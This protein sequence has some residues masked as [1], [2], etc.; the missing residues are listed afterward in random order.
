MAFDLATAK[1][2]TPTQSGGFDLSTAKPVQ[3]P[4]QPQQQSEGFPG[5]SFIEPAATIASAIPAEILGG[6][7]TLLPIVMG[8]PDKA[9][10]N[11]KAMRELITFQP[12]T[13]AGKE[14][15]ESFG[16]A[17]N[18]K[19]PVIDKSVP[20]LLQNTEDAFSKS[21][22]QTFD[23][24]GLDPA[25]GAG[26]GAVIP[27][28]IASAL[29]FK[30]A[31]TAAKTPSIKK[32]T[33]AINEL[34]L[35]AEDAV[36]NLPQTVSN[37]AK[38]TGDV[39]TKQSKFKQGI[40][41]QIEAGGTDN[42][43]A[44]FIVNGAGKVKKD[45]LAIESIKQGF[46]KGVIAAVKGASKTDKAILSKMVTTMERGKLNAKF[47]MKN[48]PSDLAGD[49]LLKRVN[50]VKKVN[51]RA[52]KNI[53]KE[54]VKL[55]GKPVDISKPVNQFA[56]DLNDLGVTLSDNGTGG[57]KP[58]FENSVLAPGDR[59]P[60]REVIRQMNIKGKNGAPDGFTTHKMKR[61]ID[62]N[63]TF[64]KSKTGMSGDAE[65]VLKDFRR[66]L[67]KSL[68]DTF[69]DYNKANTVYAETINSL[70]SLKDVAGR[71][72]DLFGPNADK[73]TGTLL[74]RMMSNAQ[75][76]VNLI[77][78]VDSLESTAKKYGAKFDDDIATQMLFVDELD[79]V[80]GPVAKT[81]LHGEVSKAVKGGAEVAAGQRS[82]Q[83]AAIDAV[84]AGSDKFR[85]ISQEGAFKSIKDLL[86]R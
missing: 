80:F 74:R 17:V 21:G 33:T 46:D 36:K 8:D 12:R 43:L 25:V 7:S 49:S 11:L 15:L 37:V 3:Q 24:L 71:K 41:K 48:R 5:A 10:A 47:A 72:M 73:A 38:N 26:A 2:V 67:D 76:R 39:F 82:I 42:T 22:A 62:N 70:D 23:T 78:A 60:I 83:G 84:V 6:L 34:P 64:G 31:K 27:E 59:G 79:S 19:L 40:A 69:P 77:D 32:V 18:T 44:K 51:T 50:H 4:E 68:D 13:E 61:A 81:S 85:G 9:E 30:L 58:N 52:G 29:G 53:N 20:E 14:G 63:V 54:A 66:G 35:D 16:E 55:R 65:K 28:A 56:D 57:F 75:S 45:K 1:P 86:K